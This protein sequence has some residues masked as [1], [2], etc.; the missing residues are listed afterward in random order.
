VLLKELQSIWLDLDLLDKDELETKEGIIKARYDKIIEV[1]NKIQ[2]D[3][4]F[5]GSSE[6]LDEAWRLDDADDEIAFIEEE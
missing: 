2:W 4:S 3:V 1:E 6:D 5:Q